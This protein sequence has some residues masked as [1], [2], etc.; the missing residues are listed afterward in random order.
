MRKAKEQEMKTEDRRNHRRVE[1]DC[2]AKLFDEKSKKYRAIRTLDASLGGVLFEIPRNSNL[3]PGDKVGLAVD[4]KDENPL[5]SESELVSATV[6]RTKPKNHFSATVA[7]E[8]D[9][10]R[11]EGEIPFAN[12]A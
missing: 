11:P 2:A 4:W 10:R 9:F 8:F 3:H 5:F 12:A 6:I 7:V 1:I